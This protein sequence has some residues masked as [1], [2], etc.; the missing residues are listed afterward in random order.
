MY[1]FILQLVLG[2][3]S[4]SSV[5]EFYWILQKK[6]EFTFAKSI[7]SCL[8]FFLIMVSRVA[9]NFFVKMVEGGSL[10][11]VLSILPI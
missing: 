2:N 5:K 8:E 7:L 6:K 10:Q 4:F 3:L 11:V 9:C 1:N